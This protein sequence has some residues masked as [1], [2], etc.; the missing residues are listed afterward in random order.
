MFLPLVVSGVEGI[1]GNVG[2][3]VLASLYSLFWEN[4]L[5]LASLDYHRAGV[6]LLFNI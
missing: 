2:E 3:T 6:G 5:E 4:E 1:C